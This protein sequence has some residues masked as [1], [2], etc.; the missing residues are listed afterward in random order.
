MLSCLVF[1]VHLGKLFIHYMK[2]AGSKIGTDKKNIFL[3]KN[4]ESHWLSAGIVWF[5]M[6]LSQVQFC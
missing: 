1:T 3:D 4:M 6:P 5:G 2:L